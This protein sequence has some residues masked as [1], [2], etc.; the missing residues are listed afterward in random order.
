VAAAVV[1][2][3]VGGGLLAGC[4]TLLPGQGTAT[5]VPVPPAPGG[6]YSQG[7]GSGG[8]VPA[9]ACQVTIRGPGSIRVSG[10]SNRV[11]TVN[12][13]SSLSCGRGPTVAIDEIA[14]GAVT[15]TPDG[16]APVRIAAGQTAAVDSYQV[17]VSSADGSA[18]TFVVAPG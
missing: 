4:S 6:S 9:G 2:V 12:G 3:L 15:L 5:S 17:T 11:S 14:D 1:A 10:A 13:A 16:G 7:G 8:S 18:A